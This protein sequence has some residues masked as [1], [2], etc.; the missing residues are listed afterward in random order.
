MLFKCK[1]WKRKNTKTKFLHYLIMNLLLN[2]N[3]KNENEKN[4]NE[5]EKRKHEINGWKT[6]EYEKRDVFIVV[7]L[8]IKLTGIALIA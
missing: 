2:K 1:L 5:T 4:P 7:L 8:P 3:E 6:M